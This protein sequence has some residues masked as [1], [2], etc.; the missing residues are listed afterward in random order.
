MYTLERSGHVTTWISLGIYL[1]AIIQFQ[2]KE[3]SFAPGYNWNLQFYVLISLS[4]IATVV[5]LFLRSPRVMLL[6]LALRFFFIFLLGL[7]LGESL[8]IELLVMTGILMS[9]G[10]M[11]SLPW[12]G[13]LSALFIVLI[14]FFQVPM[15]AMGVELESP[16]V[17]NLVT[18]AGQLFFFSLISCMF[19][20]AVNVSE[21]ERQNSFRLENALTQLS[22][23][24]IGF[25]QYAVDSGRRSKIEE[26]KR[27][28]REIHDTAGHIISNLLMMIKTSLVMSKKND[29]GLVD[30]LEKAK[31]QA[32]EG[33]VE[34]RRSVHEIYEQEEGMDRGLKAVAKLA[35]T[36]SQVTGI[37]VLLEYGNVPFRFTPDID[38]FIYRMIQEGLLNAFKHGHA[39]EVRVFF[40]LNNDTV[41]VSIVDNGLGSGK[42]NKGIGIKGMEDRIAKLNGD[43]TVRSYEGGFEL[44]AVIPVKRSGA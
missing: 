23:A 30:I 36:F 10:M 34:I 13:V 2:F 17:Y 9:T 22:D 35:K 1:L 21:R 27:I 40:W 24:N 32:E 11:V 25:Q 28:S 15:Q 6:S 26:R 8:G 3:F 33:M 12:N 37:K 4:I 44:N 14:V 7:S 43:L 38:L 29:K 19:R 5:T 41:Q 20:Y 42:V 31:K 39:S 18:F 16:D